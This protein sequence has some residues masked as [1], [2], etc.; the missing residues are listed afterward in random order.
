MAT[1]GTASDNGE[2]VASRDTTSTKMDEDRQSVDS[3]DPTATMQSALAS[4]DGMRVDAAIQVAI[5][6]RPHGQVL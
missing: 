4:F 3:A 1:N 5:K 2:D 6:P